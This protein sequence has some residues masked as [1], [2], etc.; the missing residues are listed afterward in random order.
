MHAKS[1]YSFRELLKR[2][3][4]RTETAIVKYIFDTWILYKEMFVSAFAD[5]ITH[6]GH[7]V[8]SRGESAHRMLKQYM[9]TSMNKLLS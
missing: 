9:A 8:T 3:E 5:R 4:L 2:F 7:T 1:G 6:S